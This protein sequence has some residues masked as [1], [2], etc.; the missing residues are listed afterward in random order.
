MLYERWFIIF[1]D[2][3]SNFIIKIVYTTVSRFIN[4]HMVV[5]YQL[6][7]VQW[8]GNKQINNKINFHKWLS[9]KKEETHKDNNKEKNCRGEIIK[10]TENVKH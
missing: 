2:F 9:R 5:S 7:S 10:K 3:E 1:N 8:R 4:Q 6:C